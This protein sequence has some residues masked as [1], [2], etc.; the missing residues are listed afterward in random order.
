MSA[1]DLT[2][3]SGHRDL[4]Y[5][6]LWGAQCHVVALVRAAGVVVLDVFGQHHA[7][8]VLPDDEDPVAGLPNESGKC[9]C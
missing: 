4:V 7:Q 9:S 3:W 6:I 5:R 8:V 1:L 2:G